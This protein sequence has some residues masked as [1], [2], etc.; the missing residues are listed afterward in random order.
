MSTPTLFLLGQCRDALCSR[1]IA[2]V[3]TEKAWPLHRLLQRLLWSCPQHPLRWPWDPAPETPSRGALGF[4]GGSPG[5]PPR[6]FKGIL[7]WRFPFQRVRAEPA[8]LSPKTGPGGHWAPEQWVR[9]SPRGPR[10]VTAGTRGLGG[11]WPLVCGAAWKRKAA[12]FPAPA[13]EFHRQYSRHSGCA[14]PWARRQSDNGPC[15]RGA[16]LPGAGLVGFCF[17]GWVSSLLVLPQCE[18]GVYIPNKWVVNS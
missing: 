7:A 4:A 8:P 5:G 15:P 12:T 10:S 16:C 17:S 2:G 18:L 13:S 6:F 14:P 1:D 11:R 9:A 3:G